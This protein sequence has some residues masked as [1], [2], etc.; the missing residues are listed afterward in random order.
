MTLNHP[1]TDFEVTA[2]TS[3]ISKMVQYSLQWWTDTKSYYDLSFSIR[4]NDT[5]PDLKDTQLFNIEY[6]ANGTKQTW[7]YN[8]VLC[9]L[10]S[11]TRQISWKC[12]GSHKHLFWG[13]QSWRAVTSPL[14]FHSNQWSCHLIYW[15]VSFWWPWVT[16][17]SHDSVSISLHC[18]CLYVVCQLQYASQHTCY[19]NK[20]YKVKYT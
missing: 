16:P 15:R 20:Y 10:V 12:S 9:P 11:A 13:A 14:M 4:L 19:I 18:K 2:S 8:E 3:S 17:Q 7:F 1:L 6:L 5:N